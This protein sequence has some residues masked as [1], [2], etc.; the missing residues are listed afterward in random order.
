MLKDQRVDDNRQGTLYANSS[1]SEALFSDVFEGDE[2]G[3]TAYVDAAK[4][5]MF[6]FTVVLVA[7]YL[8]SL[9]QMFVQAD[10]I[11]KPMAKLT[12]PELT[13]AQTAL[14]K[15]SCQYSQPIR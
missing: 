11:I 10:V 2:V 9:W 4:L 6:V 8:A 13:Q 3:N 14:G 1:P 12:G 7:S 5:Q 15:I